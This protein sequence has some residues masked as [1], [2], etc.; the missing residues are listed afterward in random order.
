ML[1]RTKFCRPAAP[2]DFIT[3]PRLDQML[4]QG[5]SRPLTLISA[6]AGYGKTMLMSSFLQGYALPWVW[7]SL[8]AQDNDLRLFLDYLLGALESLSPGALRGTQ[9]LLAG[10]DLPAATVIVDSLLNE[11]AELACE[12]CLVLDD[13]QE[14]QETA[15]FSFLAALLAHPLEGMHLVLLTRQDPTM[16][17]QALRARDQMSEIRTRDLRFTTAEAG[18][19]LKQAVT[20]PLQGEALV[21][22]AEQTEGWPAALRL[23]ALTLRY[24]GDVDPQAAQGHA[25]NRYVMDYLVSEVL[26]RIP[27]EIEDFLLKTSILDLLCGSLCDAVVEPAG[28]A[29]QGQS[30]LQRLE[31][32]NLF[33]M[34][35]DEQGQ[36]YR[37]HHLFQALLRRRLT[38]KLNTQEIEALHLRASA[39]YA[40]HDELEL[41]LQHALAG[42]DA[43]SAVQLVAQHR[44]ALLNTEQLPRLERWLRLFPAATLEQTPELLLV[45]VW[46][47]ELGRG[48]PAQMILHLLGQA[49]AAIARGAVSPARARQLQGEI[50]ALRSMERT[51]AADDPQGTISLATRALELMPREWYVA[52]AQ[53]WLHLAGAYQ[54]SG[55][56]DRA[57]A[58]LAA[59]Q[60][61]AAIT[62]P[63]PRLRLLAAPCFIYWMAADLAGTLQAAQQTI[64]V[65]QATDD[66]RE[67]LGWGHYFLASVYYQ[68]NDLA[69]AELHANCVQDLRHVCAHYAV[70]QSAIL[71]AEI[72]QARG[73]PAAARAVF[74]RLKSYLAEIQSVALQLFV[75]AFEAELA[76]LQGDLETAGYWAMTAGARIPLGIMPYHYAPQFTLPKVLLRMNTPASRQQ[77]AAALERLHTFVTTTH[78]TR[79]TIDVLALQAL[80]YDA[81]GDEAAALK[82][83]EQAVTLAQPGGFVRVFLDLGSAL[84]KLLERL[85]R[86][87]CATAYSEQLLAAFAA[88][89]AANDRPHPWSDRP[90]PAA[91]TVEPLTARELAVLALL[92]Q[93]LSAKE[94]A[95]HLTIT[96][97]TASSHTSN[98]FQK[99]G[100]NNRRAAVAAA[101]ALGLLP[102]P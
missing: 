1:R 44:H 94:I 80:T 20:V 43:P 23:A 100:V 92:A 79:F 66:Q 35:L 74:E 13:L 60:Q 61:E 27:P 76:A 62:S 57:Y 36:W 2:Q 38:G 24:R 9:S 19:F 18:E 72:Q 25:A 41:A 45:K 47:A 14:I 73:A 68:R 84:I 32:M 65:G 102:A 42:N 15:V 88:E 63:T 71:L 3:R 34:A 90:A 85:A 48:A 81:E 53:A 96:E 37:Y 64:T 6:P 31:A 5:L 56:L 86:R 91:A 17:L 59:A 11:L 54:S 82:A 95:Q 16:G 40:K 83:L 21:A 58:L 77:A 22:L 8:D 29:R 70:V 75:A 69:A 39:W 10:N 12:F 93:R 78:N 30:F 52:R 97:R 101:R 4:S 49:Q 33:T 46:V 98:I 99:L 50:D 7:L 51:F 28:Q 67:S 55:Q 87:G 26:A 89:S